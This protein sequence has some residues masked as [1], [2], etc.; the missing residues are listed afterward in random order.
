MPTGDPTI[1]TNTTSTGN[2]N[3]ATSTTTYWPG[4]ATATFNTSG[5]IY[6]SDVYASH[7]DMQKLKGRLD[8]IEDRLAILRVDEELQKKY[9]ALQEAYEAYKIIEN[10]V[11]DKNDIST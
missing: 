11:R 8:G 4:T 7:A 3:V 5:Y 2:G 10:L 9:P 1:Y 6:S